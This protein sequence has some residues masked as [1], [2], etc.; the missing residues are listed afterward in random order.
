MHR[1]GFKFSHEE[2][3]KGRRRLDIIH[4][5]IKANVLGSLDLAGLKI[6]I[7]CMLHRFL[8][9]QEDP[10]MSM[11]INFG[12]LR[13][14]GKGIDPTVKYTKER[15]IGS[16]ASAQIKMS[17]K[18]HGAHGQYFGFNSALKSI[19]QTPLAMVQ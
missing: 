16:M 11:H 8:L 5:F 9:S 17:T 19:V 1:V 6:F 4:A 18:W 2:T 14:C 13:L 10:R 3:G 12:I 7:V 15:E